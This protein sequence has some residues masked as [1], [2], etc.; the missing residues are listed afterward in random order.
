MMGVGDWGR[1][2]G[3]GGVDQGFNTF[4]RNEGKASEKVV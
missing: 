3:G 4:I 1:R 2:V